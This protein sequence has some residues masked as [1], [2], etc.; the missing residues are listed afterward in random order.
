MQKNTIAKITL[1]SL[2]L[3]FLLP[4]NVLAISAFDPHYIISDSDMRNNTTW[5]TNDVQSFLDSKGGYLRNYSTIDIVDNKA[6]KAA[7]VVY[8][9]ASRYNINPKVLLVTLQKEQSLITDPNPNDSQLD[10]ATGYAVCDSCSVS[11]PKVLKHK[12]FATQVDDAAYTFDWYL[13]NTDATN[14]KKAGVAT[15]I[16]GTT[17]IPKTWA[18]AALYTYTPHLHG[19]QNFDKLWKT[20]FSSAYPNGT[21]LKSASSSEIWLVQNNLRRKFK[22]MSVL[23]TR[24]DPKM[25]IT[26]PD[27]ELTKYAA[28]ND[29]F[30]PNYSILK[31]DG[32]YY[33]LD[34]DSLRP[35]A[36]FDVVKTL[37]YNPQEIVEVGQSDLI[38]LT[39]GKTII[40]TAY[41]PQGVIYK[42]SDSDYYL[43]RDGEAYP[44]LNAAVAKANFPTLSIANKK[45]A[46]LSGLIIKDTLI[47]FK[48]GALLKIS[49]KTEYYAIENGLKRKFE[50]EQAFI[51]LGYQKSNLI[52]IDLFTAQLTANGEQIYFAGNFDDNALAQINNKFLGD[53]AVNVKDLYQPALP[54][55]VIAEYPTGKI[56]SGKNIDTERSI[57]SL[58]KVMIGYEAEKQ[59]IDYTKSTA[60]DIGKYAENGYSLSIPSGSKLTN[61]D[62]IN[63]MMIG[64]YNN[65]A[66]MA[67]Q[68]TGLTET[69]MIAKV[70]ER[71]Q[72]W[73][74]NHTTITDVTGL[75][76]K[77]VSTARE[78]LKIFT[79][80]LKDN[81]YAGMVLSKTR[82]DFF[83][84]QGKLYSIR[85][86]NTLSFDNANYKIM[87]S[88]TGY[89]DEA[90]SVLMLLIHAKQD[91]KDY[92][93]ITLGD[94]D[95]TNRL[96]LPDKI[97]L[98]IAAKG[99][100]LNIASQ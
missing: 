90:Q 77:N 27:A 64:S 51:S 10:W 4:G 61:K 29:I 60:Y 1:G 86:T 66:K 25:I 73:G 93:I 15:E 16:D 87:A 71:L 70:N 21:L 39:I 97:A 19:N 22:N 36:S 46:D 23:I 14:T 74:A 7:E 42:I 95:Y 40:A 9:A 38:G 98:W 94:S 35:F 99:S 82:H 13:R 47:N 43:V 68:S 58:V 75:D 45:S 37:G 44:L 57:A 12:G 3:L 85:N 79:Y 33:L 53:L 18:T 6:K 80:I 89:T 91:N 83:T 78:L 5:T 63:T 11:D 55:Y 65:V 32:N 76:A 50:S 41:A 67:A 88:K 56:V 52:E 48:D 59:G 30:Y 24:A 8:D 31:S 49:G 84:A 34:Y 20:W 26:V 72:G 28:G 2:S 100:T 62:I 54:A 81:T 96:V 92:M 69:Q 17:V